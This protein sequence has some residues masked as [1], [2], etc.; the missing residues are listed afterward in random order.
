MGQKT[1]RLRSY[2]QLLELLE[3]GKE[4]FLS[5][6]QLEDLLNVRLDYFL[7]LYNYFKKP[8]ESSASLIKTGKVKIEDVSYSI[9]SS[10]QE[11]IFKISKK[12]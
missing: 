1:L 7:E 3:A 4:S 9:D 8:T 6:E 2:G 5:H 11:F 10:Q 12:L